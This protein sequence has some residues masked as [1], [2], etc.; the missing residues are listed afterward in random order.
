M[1]WVSRRA[2]VTPGTGS[3]AAGGAAGFE[4]TDVDVLRLGYGQDHG[5]PAKKQF[6][7]VVA[8]SVDQ[9][10]PCPPGRHIRRH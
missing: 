5:G 8:V 9:P 7:Q 3:K 6:G 4:K 10:G 1:P 2:V